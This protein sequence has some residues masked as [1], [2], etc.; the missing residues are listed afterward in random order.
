MINLGTSLDETE[1]TLR[2]SDEPVRIVEYEMSEQ[3]KQ[4]LEKDASS[5]VYRDRFVALEQE[6]GSFLADVR[7]LIMLRTANKE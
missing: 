7:R 2:S 1:T 6:L 4:L 3:S 5:A